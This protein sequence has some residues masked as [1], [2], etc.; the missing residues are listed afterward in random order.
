[1]E[2]IDKLMPFVALVVIGVFLFY[3]LRL[4]K[5]E[6]IVERREPVPI[7]APLVIPVAVPVALVAP[8]KVEAPAPAVVAAPATVEPKAPASPIHAVLELLTK[9]DSLATAFLLREIL[10]PPM[11]RRRR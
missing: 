9:K 2:P 7:A 8:S 10:D 1:M 5:R 4:A 3:L 11:S 6:P